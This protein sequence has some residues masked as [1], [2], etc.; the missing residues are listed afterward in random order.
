MFHIASD[1]DIKAGRVT[2]VYFQRALEVLRR[3]GIDKHVK[4]EV[5]LK[6]FPYQ[7]NWGVLAG[8]EECLKLME[9]LPVR[10]RCL[11]EG[12]IFRKEEPVMLIEGRYLD[13]GHYETAILGL[14]CQASGIATKAARYR[15]IAPDKVLISFG[16][17]RM[18]PTIAPMVER[19]AFIAGFD[20]VAAVKAAE[21]LGEPAMGT[22]PHALIILLGDTVEAMRAFHEVIEP[23]VKRVAL[24]DT[25]HDEKFEAVRVAQA[26]GEALYGVRLDT[27]ASRRGDF[28][29]ILKEVRWELDVRG[30]RHVKLFVSGGLEEDAVEQLKGVADAFGIGT[31]IT[32]A[33]TIDFALDIVEVEGE[34]LAKRG[35]LSGAKKLLRCDTCL[36]DIVVL[37]EAKRER[38][39]CGGTLNN[40]TK[41]YISEGKLTQELPPPQEIR[42]YVL[43]QLQDERLM[44]YAF[45]EAIFEG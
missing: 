13:F 31:S 11:P 21:L 38:C 8:V 36:Q 1:E 3:K 17:R 10:V 39:Y 19:N 2:D 27:P 6:N 43:A 45:R 7:E 32:N 23:N 9:G 42:K 26:M 25:F 40:L 24:I 30:F 22:M 20:G 5:F 28:L 35:K 44:G 15:R 33:R 14:L 41:E 18:H 16:A 12:T 4:M 34:K 29:K 37:E